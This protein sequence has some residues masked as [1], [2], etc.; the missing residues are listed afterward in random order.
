MKAI[1]IKPAIRLSGEIILPG[2]KSISHR[3]AILAALSKGRTKITNFLFSDDCLV[4]LRVLGILG[5]KIRTDKNRREVVIESDGKLRRPALALFMRESGTSARIFLGLLAGQDFESEMT[6]AP[7]LLRRPMKRVLD[8]IRLMGGCIAASKEEDE[9]RLPVKIFPAGLKG[10]AWRQRE[11]SAQVKSAVLLAGLFAEGP[12]SIEEPFKTRDH[13]ER[14][15]KLFG[16]A[17]RTKG[18][19]I[20]IQRSALVSP[21][22]IA[23]PGDVSTA[24]FFIVSAL[25]VKDSRIVIKEVG[26]NPT[27][28]GAL[29]VLKRM[30]ANVKIFNR[31]NLPEPVAD[32][33]AETSSLKGTTILP[34]EIPALIDELPVLMV[35]AGLAQGKMVIHGSSELRLKETDRIRSMQYNLSKLGVNII[36]KSLK[37]NETIE[38][39][40][41]KSFS[42]A[43]FK[44]FSDH[45]TAMSMYVAA[46]A[47]RNASSLDDISCVAKSFPEFSNSMKHLVVK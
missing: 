43:K 38:I 8:P 6:A 2:D 1:K 12:T 45:R 32:I 18:N 4:T 47:S 28:L 10:I 37:N 20:T 40:G 13:T 7:S 16:A 22:N 41:T 5:I 46:L 24:A 25:L 33:E 30:G 42:G 19:L 39:H 27:R 31:R 23:I 3:A 15:L 11:A 35:A 44:S 21:G 14:M 9:E 36:V 17:I 34:E 26:V 29:N